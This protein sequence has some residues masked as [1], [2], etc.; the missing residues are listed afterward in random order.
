MKI[1]NLLALILL[2]TYA[3]SEDQGDWVDVFN[4]PFDF[5]VH[6]FYAGY[7]KISATKSYFYVYHPSES[8][9]SKDPLV[10]R[11]SAGP[12][13]SP[14]Y[15]WLYS[16]G[17]FIFTPGTDH[18]RHNPNNWNKEANV[19]FIE[20]PAGVGFSYDTEKNS[21]Q[22]LNDVEFAFENLKALF[23]FYDKFPELKDQALYLT[24]EQ[25][26]GMTIPILAEMIVRHNADKYIP[27]W[28]RINLK[29]FLLENP[30][31]LRD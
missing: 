21:S 2:V 31:T 1:I 19:L 4:L 7:L 9:P 12:G 17:P 30:C 22:P 15:S 27:I 14:M 11:I 23:S 24:G 20:G 28:T 16:K 26:A 3:S 25:Y 29:G 6:P 13:C 18:F 8:N 5:P 10:V